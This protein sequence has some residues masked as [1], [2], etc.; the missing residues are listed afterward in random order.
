MRY[1]HHIAGFTL[2]EFMLSVALGLLLLSSA[3]ALFIAAMKNSEAVM[4]A[5]Q[6][7]NAILSVMETLASDIQNADAFG[8]SRA[9]ARN[10]HWQGL[11]GDASQL[12]LSYQGQPQ[13]SL[14]QVSDD[15]LH[16]H[17]EPTH[18]FNKNM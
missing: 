15:G 1:R 6:K 3:F 16:I 12:T 8:C 7:Q 5:Q 11:R 9:C 14:L 4:L 13:L 10:L 17:L 2:L 18:R